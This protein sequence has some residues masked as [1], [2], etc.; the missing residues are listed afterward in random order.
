MGAFGFAPIIRMVR[1][2]RRGKTCVFH[3]GLIIRR[4]CNFFRATRL[5][6]S[7]LV[8]NFEKIQNINTTNFRL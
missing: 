5:D 4:V 6:F 2:I 3:G 7:Y 1:K 8:I